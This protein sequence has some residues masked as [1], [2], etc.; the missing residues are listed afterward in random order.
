MS[1][2]T[3]ER[4]FSKRALR[5]LLRELSIG[6]PL[7]FGSAVLFSLIFHDPLSHVFAHVFCTG[8]LLQT[9]IELGRYG[10]T[11]FFGNAHHDEVTSKIVWPGWKWMVPWIIFSCVVAYFIG[12]Y[13]GYLVMGI[14]PDAKNMYSSWRV[15]ALILTVVLLI[16]LGSAYVLYTRVKMAALQANT[17]ALLR[18]AAESQLRLLESQLEPHMLFNTLANLR[19]LIS[20]DPARAQQMLDRLI[21]FFRAT[22]EASRTGSHTLTAEFARIADYLEL[23]KVR[24]GARL[25]S[26]MELAPELARLTVPALLLQPLVENAIKHGLEA[27]AAGGMILIT[28]TLDGAELVLTVRDTGVGLGANQHLNQ[29]LNQV[30]PSRGFGLEQVRARLKTLYGDAASFTLSNTPESEG[31]MAMIRF[32]INPKT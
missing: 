24:M 6:L 18:G 16:A 14:T 19:V 25:Q 15:L 4:S 27:K 26:S 20:L 28:A 21:S 22:L 23:M 31:V 11:H 1:E 7:M 12:R 32:P 10:L 29:H 30:S 5:W 13:L 8:I 9:L 2:I 17:E 3:P